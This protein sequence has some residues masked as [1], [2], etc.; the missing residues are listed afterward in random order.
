VVSRTKLLAVPVAFVTAVL[1]STTASADI[2]ALSYNSPAHLS[3]SNTE[4][5]VTGLVVCSMTDVHANV[6]VSIFQ[7]QGRQLLIASGS[8]S[9]SCLTAGSGSPQPWTVLA[10]TSQGQ[11]L[12]TGSASINITAFND[13]FNSS[14]SVAGPISLTH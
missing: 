1:L 2:S 6:F 13:T 10:S 4:A 14:K 3:V 5:T 9:V 7:S 8:T 11:A 12:K